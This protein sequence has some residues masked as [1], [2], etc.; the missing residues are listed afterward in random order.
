MRRYAPCIVLFIF[1][2]ACDTRQTG[3]Q[4]GAATAKGGEQRIEQ[5]ALH[6]YDGGT[7]LW[8]LETDLL[9][10]SHGDTP[11]QVI[12]VQMELFTDTGTV[13]T[14][15]VADSGLTSE[16][17]DHF[18]LW[19]AV[20]IETWDG[21]QIRSETLYWDKETRQLHSPD[22]VEIQLP[23]GEKMW[24]RGFEAAEDFSWWVFHED[25]QGEFRNF[26]ALIG[27]NEG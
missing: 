11:I 21:K 13:G 5:T 3:L 18:R 22:Y 1:L 10:R 2:S 4:K 7:L 23:S 27:R 17:M 8:V 19:G 25:V 16:S 12:P 20:S 6:A 9:Y 24:G 26:E 15:V 14:N